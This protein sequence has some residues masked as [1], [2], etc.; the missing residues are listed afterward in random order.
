MPDKAKR[1][2]RRAQSRR[3]KARN[4]REE[5]EEEKAEAK[6]RRAQP[7]R[8]K[9]RNRREEEEKITRIAR[10]LQRQ[11]ALDCQ[12]KLPAAVPQGPSSMISLVAIMEARSAKVMRNIARYLTSRLTQSYLICTGCLTT[13]NTP[14][15]RSYLR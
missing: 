1:N 12:Q 4:R 11:L 7:Q 10:A 8:D 2:R 6:R 9:A 5:E 13:R 15:L 3:D 14:M